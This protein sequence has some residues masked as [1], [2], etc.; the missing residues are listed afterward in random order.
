MKQLKTFL[1]PIILM[2]PFQAYR[3]NSFN[4]YDLRAFSLQSNFDKNSH[5]SGNNLIQAIRVNIHDTS[6]DQ[7]LNNEN[8]IDLI[9]GIQDNLFPKPGSSYL[10]ETDARGGSSSKKKSTLIF[11]QETKS[12]HGKEQ[13]HRGA[14]DPTH[15]ENLQNF[16]KAGIPIDPMKDPR[17]KPD[18]YN[19][20]HWSKSQKEWILQGERKIKLSNGKVITEKEWQRMLIHHS[21]QA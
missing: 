1:V 13:S 14:S 7:S 15:P 17:K 21:H 12:S 18:D 19:S 11:R 10:E 4:E 20:W 2:N 8:D 3:I 9:S 5:S 6:E 16:E